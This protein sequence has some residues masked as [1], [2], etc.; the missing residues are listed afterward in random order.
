[1]QIHAFF[2]TLCGYGEIGKRTTLRM[3]RSLTLGV[4]LPLTVCLDPGG[5][6]RLVPYK[7]PVVLPYKIDGLPKPLGEDT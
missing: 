2:E 4:Q 6:N 7:H 3:W 1:M 5:P